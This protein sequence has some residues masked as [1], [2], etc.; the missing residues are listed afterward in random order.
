[1]TTNTRYRLDLSV[2][3]A[4]GFLAVLGCLGLKLI[5]LNIE[6]FMALLGDRMPVASGLPI[7]GWLVDLAYV[8]FTGMGAFVLW[9]ITSFA[10]ALWLVVLLDR[11][12]HRW[13]I[14]EADADRG[15]SSHDSPE[16]RRLLRLPFSFIQLSPLVGL[17]ALVF[18]V[19]VQARF[20]ELVQW[21]LFLGG[22]MIG[23]VLGINGDQVLAMAFNLCAFE[24]LLVLVI[25]TWGWLTAHRYG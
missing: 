11:K 3:L 14:R 9:G 25:T 12:A 16:M 7:I 19:I 6:P 24:V 21:P 23:K 8:V 4:S 15:V 22:L 5:L 10:E 17:A 2:L 18:D 1:M 20:F 13:A